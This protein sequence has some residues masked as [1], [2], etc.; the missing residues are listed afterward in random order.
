MVIKRY[1]RILQDPILR[2]C[3]LVMVASILVLGIIFALSYQAA[4]ERVLDGSIRLARL[5]VE[6]ARAIVERHL[7][8]IEITGNNLSSTRIRR[9][10]D[11]NQ[12]YDLLERFVHTNPEIW[13]IAIGYETEVIPG[14]EKGFAPYVKRKGSH[15]ERIDLLA[16]GRLYRQSEWYTTTLNTGKPYWC[17]PFRDVTGLL[18]ACYCVPLRDEQERIIGVIAVDL[19]LDLF[20]DDLVKEIHP[21]EHSECMVLDKDFDFIAHPNHSFI[22]TSLADQVWKLTQ[23]NGYE[24]NESIM[25]RM[26]NKVEGYDTYAEDTHLEGVMFYLPIEQIGWTVAL[27]ILK[28]DIFRESNS[29][30]HRLF[31]LCL[32]GVFLLVIGAGFLFAKVRKVVENRV[33]IECELTMA[34]NIQMAMVKKAYPAYPDRKD[35]D[36]YATLIPAKDV[37]GDLYDF[38]LQ[39]DTLHF[40]IGDVSGK[41]VPASL[42]MAITRTLY[43]SIIV[44]ENSPAK[45]A[46]SLNRS[47]AADNKENM[48]ITMYIGA[49]DLKQ[50][51]LTLCNCG[52]NAP[53]TNATAHETEVP[54]GQGLP[55]LVDSGDV[56]FLSFPKINIPIGV[57]EEFAFEEIS[58]KIDPGF[59]LFLFTDGVTEAENAAH[60]LYG[61]ERLRQELNGMKR[62]TPN[63]QL[64][65]E[66]IL[67]TVHLHAN[68]YSQS[69][70]ITMLSFYYK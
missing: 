66:H 37:G 61:E 41:G 51:I 62:K 48:F 32:S 42:F 5:N 68:G 31:F 24:V 8:S 47:I 12:I 7:T 54:N 58:V 30:A 46:E 6:R 53:L 10:R 11:A 13:G 33:G 1:L 56:Q 63:A 21:Y 23:E 26:K 17:K 40:C 60:Q 57:V 18:I 35:I 34:H 16:E 22:M 36:I 15:T 59:Q 9:Y 25:M 55:H 67:N 69:D 19:Q 65:V 4:S 44:N 3:L 14:H 52:H 20:T 45:I 43:R 27:S 50:G 2:I 70:D 39:G 64:D 28:S 38:A 49:L 29:M